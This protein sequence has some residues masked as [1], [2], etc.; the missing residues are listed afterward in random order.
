MRIVVRIVRLL[1]DEDPDVILTTVYMVPFRQAEAA[2][3]DY[4][5]DTCF[6]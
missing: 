2:L 4:K 6:C 5:S 3:V 1:L